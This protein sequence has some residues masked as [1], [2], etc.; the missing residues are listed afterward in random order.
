MFYPMTQ[1]SCRGFQISHKKQQRYDAVLVHT[2]TGT[3]CDGLTARPAVQL[4]GRKVNCQLTGRPIIQL[5]GP[6]LTGRKAK[7]LTVR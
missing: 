5:T 2:K 1:Y 4:T 7:Q 3:G 6:E